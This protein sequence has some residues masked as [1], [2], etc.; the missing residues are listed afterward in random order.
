M[1]TLDLHLKLGTKLN[2]IMIYFL[3]LTSTQD[4]SRKCSAWKG[5]SVMGDGG[6]VVDVVVVALLLLMILLYC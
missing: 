5:L 1:I 2:N 6:V 3:R 4:L